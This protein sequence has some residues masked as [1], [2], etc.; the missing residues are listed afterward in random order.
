MKKT[1][2]SEGAKP[3]FT[4]NPPSLYINGR[5]FPGQLV[6]RL[7]NPPGPIRRGHGVMAEHIQYFGNTGNISACG[8]IIE[9]PERGVPTVVLVDPPKQIGTSSL[10][11][12]QWLF[13]SIA[14]NIIPNADPRVVN[15]HIVAD[16]RDE[17]FPRKERYAVF[18]PV[19]HWKRKLRTWNPFKLLTGRA[20]GWRA[21][22]YDY[23]F[24][25]LERGDVGRATALVERYWPQIEEDFPYGIST[26]L[27][28]FFI[29]V[30]GTPG[31]R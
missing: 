9:W 25:Q 16:R 27:N 26:D 2:E 10:T 30:Y 3:F 19:T 14:A 21:D 31:P 1:V 28:D 18:A 29:S 4:H 20:W 7:I 15:W 24:K 5:Y 22:S 23:D 8:M 6:G 12:C 11:A 13:T 17:D